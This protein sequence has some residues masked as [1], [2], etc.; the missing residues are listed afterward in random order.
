MR[1]AEFVARTDSRWA[2]DF[3][4][5]EGRWA[6]RAL[7]GAASVA[8]LRVVEELGVEAALRV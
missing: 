3:H 4:G 6:R 7:C 5:S 8:W 2:E 1:L